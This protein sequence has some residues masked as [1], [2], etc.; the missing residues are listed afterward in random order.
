[1]WR[2]MRINFMDKDNWIKAL[3]YSVFYILY[4]MLIVI[5]RDIDLVQKTITIFVNWLL[6][7]PTYMLVSSF[8]VGVFP[9]KYVEPKRSK[10]RNR[11]SPYWNLV[12][13]IKEYNKSKDE[14]LLKYIMKEV[15]NIEERKYFLL[16][17]VDS[18]KE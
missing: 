1:M 13:M 7:L 11:L 4:I 5:N 15:E 8:I 6:F 10:I 9:K 16:E 2:R 14:E 3:F 17:L 18:I 12:A